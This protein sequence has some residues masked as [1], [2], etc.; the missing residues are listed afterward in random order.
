[1]KTAEDR[2]RDNLAEPLDR[3]T[4]RRILGDGQMCPYPIVVGSISRENP[5]QMDLAKDDEVI[6]AFPADR[7]DATFALSVLPGGTR[8]GW[9]IP[10]AQRV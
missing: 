3:P 2:S 4:A 5:A 10:N 7:T 9:P 6:E 8:G 1:M